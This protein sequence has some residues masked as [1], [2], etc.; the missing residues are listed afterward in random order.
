MLKVCA[1]EVHSSYVLQS[2]ET[3]VSNIRM[4]HLVGLHCE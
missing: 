4:V 2:Y 1:T 3:T